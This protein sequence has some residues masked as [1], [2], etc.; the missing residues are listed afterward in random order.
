MKG[1]LH[2]VI[3]TPNSNRRSTLAHAINYV[4]DEP[5]SFF[6]L[7]H[8][9]DFF[10]LPGTHWMWTDNKFVIKNLE[11]DKIDE[12]FLFFSNEIDLADQFETLKEFIDQQEKLEIGRI[13]TFINADYLN[14]IDPLLQDWIDGCAHFSDAFCFS[15]RT[16]QNAQALSSLLDRYKT[17]RYPM[18]T[19]IL[20][21]SKAPPIDNILCPVSRRIS[22][23]FDPNDLLDPNE[24]PDNDPFL[25]RQPN[26]KRIKNLLLPSWTKI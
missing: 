3:G 8:K 2:I 16:N 23:I 20:A 18:E 9:L 12:W 21:K 10:D 1:V 11:T 5:S 4:E 14:E 15:N 26:G 17:M 13:L 24:T 22:H 25:V 7:P 19:F 6:L